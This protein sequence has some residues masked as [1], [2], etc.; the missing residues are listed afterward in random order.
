MAA[1]MA[2]PFD[3]TG[4]AWADAKVLLRIEG[5]AASVTYRCE[6]LVQRLGVAAEI[7]PGD[8]RWPAIRDVTA[9][10]GKPGDVWR[11]SVKPSDAPGIIA[12]AGAETVVLD[13]AGGLIW[14]LVEPG[15]DLRTR[16]GPFGG[17]AT[18]I[19]GD[20]APIATFHPEPA[21]VARL[22]AGLKARFDPKGLLNPGLLG[23]T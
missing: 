19:R 12:R 5:F 18:R 6:A 10:H 2:S 7:E 9:F 4:A 8:A 3:V 17:H 15:A 23:Q 14:L 1:A 20:R 13:W 16:I 22:T 11:L 21:A